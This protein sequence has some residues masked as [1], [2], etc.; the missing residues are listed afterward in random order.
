M[1]C[2]RESQPY[3]DVS[4]RHSNVVRICLQVLRSGHDSKLYGPFVAEGL[5]GPFS[6]GSDLFHGGNSVVGNEHLVDTNQLAAT[7]VSASRTQQ[8]TEVMT[9]CPSLSFTKSFTRPASAT[10]RWLPPI[11]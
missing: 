7:V 4:V 11:K 10:P 3:L 9:V 6:D 5:V 8:L 2:F 1:A